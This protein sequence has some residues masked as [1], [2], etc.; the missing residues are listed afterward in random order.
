[1]MMIKNDDK[2]MA[3]AEKALPIFFLRYRNEDLKRVYKIIDPKKALK[4]PLK[5]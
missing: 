2:M 1:M 5:L 3:T 4:S